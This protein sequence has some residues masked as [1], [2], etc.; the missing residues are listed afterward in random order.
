MEIDHNRTIT[1]HQNK[2]ETTILWRTQSADMQKS[3]KNCP[4]P[5]CRMQKQ[6]K[7]SE[8]HNQIAGI[9]YRTSV[10]CVA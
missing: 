7:R 4:I 6:K 1:K 9:L 10:Q 5:S 3:L 2:V 8:R